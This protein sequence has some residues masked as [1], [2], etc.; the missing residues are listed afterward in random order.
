MLSSDELL[1][2]RTIPELRALVASFSND[3]ESKK[4]EL[5]H[6]VGSKYHDFIQSADLI[7]TMRDKVALMESKLEAFS[8]C[9]QD[10]VTKTQDLLVCT[11][12]GKQ[13]Q[14][15]QQ[16]Q[17]A[18]VATMSFASISSSA[19]WNYL[20]ECHVYEAAKIVV[21]AR[22]VTITSNGSSNSSNAASSSSSALPLAK[23]LNLNGLFHIINNSSIDR[24]NCA[25]ASFLLETVLDDARLLLLAG[26]TSPVEK[27]QTLACIGLLAGIHI[28]IYTYAH[29]R[30]LTHTHSYNTHTRIHT[31]T[32]I[33]T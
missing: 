22:L 29:T 20:E 14:Q 17:Q 27:A 16:Q 25:S 13:Q 5:Q 33:H 15:Q 11:G 31:H 3:A 6:M 1:K 2:T 8:A 32:H 7:S 10:L 28:L 21:L 4:L 12:Q 26:G 23:F 19:V 9:S 24:S 30:H 18:V